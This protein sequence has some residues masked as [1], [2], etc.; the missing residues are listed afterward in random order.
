ML[1]ASDDNSQ[2]ITLTY[3][4]VTPEGEDPLGGYLLYTDSVNNYYYDSTDKCI[5]AMRKCP[6]VT[7]EGPIIDQKDQHSLSD[8][9]VKM[10]LKNTDFSNVKIDLLPDMNVIKTYQYTEVEN[11][12][13]TGAMALVSIS[14]K[15]YI[16]SATFI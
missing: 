3:K 16:E 13:G 1:S 11:N 12:V 2:I 7:E 8:N 10:C 4:G 9:L 6:E 14:D 15:G 5:I